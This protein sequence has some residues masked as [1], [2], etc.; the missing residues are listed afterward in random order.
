M[1]TEGYASLFSTLASV[2]GTV[3]AIV[4]GIAG[5]RHVQLQA[6]LDG[7]AIARHEAGI[8]VSQAEA[9]VD[10]ACRATWPRLVKDVTSHGVFLDQLYIRVKNWREHKKNPDV[11]EAGVQELARLL[12]P[13]DSTVWQVKED[14]DELW[15]DI[16]RIWDLAASTLA[17]FERDK[18]EL[19]PDVSIE[20]VWEVPPPNEE[21]R[22]GRR[23]I[24]VYQIWRGLLQRAA[25]EHLFDDYVELRTPRDMREELE[26]EFVRNAAE[27]RAAISR[28]RDAERARVVTDAAAPAMPSGLRADLAVLAVV[29]LLAVLPPILYVTPGPRTSPVSIGEAVTV[30]ILFVV[31][32]IVFMGHLAMRLRAL[33]LEHGGRTLAHLLPP[34]GEDVPGF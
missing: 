3:V 19:S 23:P 26:Q 17:D 21:L 31:G 29:A 30:M 6:Q 25:R 27:V 9:A 22:C 14:D 15:E 16:Q 32:L 8:R 18:V 1:A 33:R 2:G 11:R 10:N 4:G 12:R 20:S 34:A 5:T 13:L 24:R 7:S 28:H